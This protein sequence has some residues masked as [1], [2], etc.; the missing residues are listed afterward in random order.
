M[1]FNLIQED[2]NKFTELDAERT[3][4]HNDS[5]SVSDFILRSGF[6]GSNISYQDRKMI[7]DKYNDLYLGLSIVDL[8]SKCGFNKF[9]QLIFNGQGGN[10]NFWFT[11]NGDMFGDD[12]AEEFGFDDGILKFQLSQLHGDGFEKDKNGEYYFKTESDRAKEALVEDMFNATA[13]IYASVYWGVLMNLNN[14]ARNNNMEVRDL[15]IKCLG[16][17]DYKDTLSYPELIKNCMDQ[18][19]PII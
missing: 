11:Y 5:D 2:S 14:F 1:S 9:G 17:M 15:I 19:F 3:L 8:P 16:N 18:T 6:G 13:E 12:M 7:T 10:M 4:L